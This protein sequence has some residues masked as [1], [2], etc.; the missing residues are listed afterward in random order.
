MLYLLGVL[1]FAIGLIGSI[2]LHEVG[3]MVPAKK[4]GVKVT[5]YMVG[6]GP[7]LWSRRRGDTEYGIK[8]IPLGG[9]IRMIGMIPPRQ[10]G[11]PSR[12]PRR[13]ADLAEDF[14]NASRA[15]VQ[16]GD[17][18]REFY[19]LPPWKK[20][21]VM[22]G[23]PSMNLLIYL[24]LTVLLLATIGTKQATDRV[25][26][27]SRCAV[28]AGV[29][30]PAL[31]ADGTCPPGTTPAPAAAILRA[32][33]R[34]LAIDGVRMKKWSD[35]VKVIEASAGK[36]L[37]LTIQRDGA[38]R[39][40]S[41]TP[42]RN[43]KYVSD[44]SQQTRQAGFIGVGM[45][46]DYSAVPLTQIPGQIGDQIG[47]GFS[48][49]ASFPSKIG[50]LFGTVFEGTKRDPS[51]AVGIVGLGR[52][53][54]EV[55]SSKNIDLLDKV[56]FLLFLLAGVNLLLFLFNLLPLLPLDGGHVAAAMVESVKRRLARRRRSGVRAGE[57]GPAPPRQIYVDT[58]QM[59]PVLY[60]VAAVLF[61]FTLLVLYADIVRPITLGG[62]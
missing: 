16:S 60:G 43:L 8:A 38:A 22:A 37:T 5:Q 57:L 28:P 42:V 15:D 61:A 41:L 18:Q 2:A 35:T 23:G 58:A 44:T 33:D 26:E 17:E 48:A 56:Y 9:Y 10:D 51:G 55:A 25:Q 30:A 47:Q 24:V 62:G 4:F 21:I 40:V 1:V 11:K 50:S 3:H 36:R 13:L 52:I 29:T 19:R 39:T 53:G 32:G 49:L 14:R 34:I 20:I 45:A 46:D 31:P 12:W 6:F 27:V 54:G 59:V 7:T